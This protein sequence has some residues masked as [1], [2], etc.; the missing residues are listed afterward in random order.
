MNLRLCVLLAFATI[1]GAAL[2]A[3]PLRAEPPLA[4]A[5]FNAEQASEFHYNNT[6]F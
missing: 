2:S 3:L 6:I 4:K 1:T 5:P